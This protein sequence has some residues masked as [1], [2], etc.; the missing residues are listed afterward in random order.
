M[1][2]EN[3][4]QSDCW[5]HVVA[6][7]YP[8][9]LFFLEK[10]PLQDFGSVWTCILGVSLTVGA[11]LGRLIASWDHTL[12]FSLPVGAALGRLIVSWDRMAG[13]VAAERRAPHPTFLRQ[14]LAQYPTGQKRYHTPETPTGSADIGG[15]ISGLPQ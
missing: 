13:P 9:G 7:Y 10:T 3:H 4:P 5:E 8:Q 6:K 2:L 15:F 11:E 1:V 14:P 12:G